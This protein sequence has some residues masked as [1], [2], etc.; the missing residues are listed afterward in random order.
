MSFLQKYPKA[1]QWSF[2][3]LVFFGL[4]FAIEV[5]DGYEFA[6]AGTE[7]IDKDKFLF[8]FFEVSCKPFFVMQ[9]LW[10]F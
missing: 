9:R 3:L 5:P 8:K 2:L 7:F 4:C 10:V 1:V 6:K